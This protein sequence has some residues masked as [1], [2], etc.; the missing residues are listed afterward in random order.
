MLITGV[1]S[2]F[3][4]NVLLGLVCI[5]VLGCG[6]PRGAGFQSEVLAAS[7]E[8]VASD[9]VTP[10]YNFAVFEVTQATLPVLT[11]WPDIKG[12]AY[13]WVTNNQSVTSLLI[14]PG[15]KMQLTIW[16]AEENSLLAGQGQRA[17]PL[18]DIEVSA[19][20]KIFVPYIGD[21]KVSG[22]APNTARARIEDELTQTIPSA[23]VQLT[24]APG[25]I[26]TVNLVTGVAAPGIYPL[27]YRNLKLLDLLSQAGGVIPD[28]V[29]PQI[30]LSRGSRVYGIPYDR[31][32]QNPSLD[33]TVRGGDR[34]I[35]EAE[36]RYFLSLGATGTEALHTFPKAE[37]SAL[38]ALSIIGG[39]NDARANPQAIL[40]LREYDRSMLRSDFAGPPQDRVV[41]TIDLTTADGLFSAARFPIQPNDLIYGTESALVPALSL[42][43]IATS[44]NNAVR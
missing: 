42:F 7:S 19:S 3:F 30:R 28:M 2:L 11:S 18:Q 32:L 31:L 10:K 43:S 9:G 20:G 16:D 36:E 5:G 14:Q 39:V 40:I 33:T 37:V 38:D 26:N 12:R 8:E 27:E 17:T 15:D 23:Q 24:V 29:N 21:L 4:R 35:V 44:V 22:M 1:G 6:S 34:I 25:R 13:S 41:F